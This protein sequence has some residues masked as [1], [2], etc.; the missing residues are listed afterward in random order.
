MATIENQLNDLL[1]RFRE[2]HGVANI[3]QMPLVTQFQSGPHIRP[4]PLKNERGVY[5]FFQN[6]V[7][8]RIGQTGY[9]PRFT[10]QHYGTKRAGST[11]AAD[12]W[13]NRLEFGFAG[14][15]TQ[16]GTWIMG[17]FGR[18]NVR[19]SNDPDG[20]ISRLLEAY[21]HLHLKPRFEGSRKQ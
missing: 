8:L 11:F 5:L 1:N 20:F 15:E 17:N 21:L 2:I 16:I 19:I 12:I 4:S 3:L 18:A 6:Q 9:S 14:D 10:S 13:A 7:W